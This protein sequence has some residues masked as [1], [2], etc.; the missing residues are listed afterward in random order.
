MSG[1]AA[2]ASAS[3]S[4]A[5]ADRRAFFSSSWPPATYTFSPTAAHAKND[6]RGPGIPAPR[7]HAP[8]KKSYTNTESVGAH[9][10][11]SHPPTTTS[12]FLPSP[13][14]TAATWQNRGKLPPCPGSSGRAFHTPSAVSNSTIR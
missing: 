2:H 11:G 1:R 13:P 6:R 8:V 10:S 12:R 14:S 9:V 7:R 5:R 3:G 4:Y